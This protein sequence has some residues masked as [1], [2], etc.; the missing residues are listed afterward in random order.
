MKEPGKK[1]PHED[2]RPN[3]EFLIKSIAEQG[4]SLET[5]L[6]DLIDNSISANADKIEVL[7]K[8]NEEP[9]VL[10]LSDNGD[11][12]NEAALVRNL[13]FPSSSIDDIREAGDMG[14]F[15]LGM[16]TAS[17]AQTRCF[18]VIS[19]EKGTREYHARTWDVAYLR[20]NGWKIIINSKES[21][22][23]LLSQYRQISNE[24]LNAFSD[25]IPNTIIVWKGLYKYEEYLDE[26][27]RRDALKKEISGNISDHLSMVFHRFLERRRNKVSIRINNFLL[28]SFN[29][30][31]VSQ[32]DFRPIEYK[33]RSIENDYIKIEGFILPSRS[34]DEARKGNSIWTTA[35]KSL[36]DMEGMYVYRADRLIIYGG[37][38]GI[39]SKAPRLQ[40]ARLKVEVGNSVDHRLQ[41]NVSKSRIVVPYDLKSAF[42]DYIIFLKEQAE[43]EYYNRGVQ[44]L[45]SIKGAPKQMLFEKKPS[46]K[47]MLLEINPEFLLLKNLRDSLNSS[48]KREIDLIIKM[49]NTTIN[50]VKQAHEDKYFTGNIDDDGISADDLE[51]MVRRLK[52]NGIS[53]EQIM[54]DIIPALGFRIDTIPEIIINLIHE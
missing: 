29:P 40:L 17:F 35:G 47:G 38:N 34:I 21:V 43:K 20:K 42:Y 3:A 51:M 37:W 16:K 15:G 46:S 52:S 18:T 1:I 4:Y 49:I 36:M 8:T 10:F 7:I 6:A 22:A 19:R 41:L 32:T 24:C 30:F 54:D 5:S 31:P 14:R 48:Q 23:E 26:F 44:K 53:S 12:M 2:A 45:T 25:Y 39:I 9:F 28:E 33:Q 11:G 50:T 13:Q 27:K